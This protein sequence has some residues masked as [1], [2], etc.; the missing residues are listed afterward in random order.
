VLTQVG[1]VPDPPD[2]PVP[3][4]LDVRLDVRL[5]T[6][7]VSG[8]VTAGNPELGAGMELAMPVTV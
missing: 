8:V 6:A 3:V 2:P 7:P 4:R 5:V 1:A